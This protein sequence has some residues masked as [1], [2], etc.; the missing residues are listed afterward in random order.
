MAREA[1]QAPHSPSLILNLAFTDQMPTELLQPFCSTDTAR[2]TLLRPFLQHEHLI[3]TDG[4]IF[5][6]IPGTDGQPA[7][8]PDI[9]PVLLSIRAALEKPRA[10]LPTLPEE[11]LTVPCKH[12]DGKGHFKPCPECDGK[13]VTKCCECEQERTCPECKGECVVADAS[14]KEPCDHCEGKGSRLVATAIPI[15]DSQYSDILLKKLVE[16]L[17]IQSFHPN[18]PYVSGFVGHFRANPHVTFIGGLMPIRAS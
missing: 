12:C 16:H 10:P 14:G 13:G 2:P 7:L 4:R 9:Y 8:A 5:I 6:A 3:G 1:Q 17:E 11:G 18:G 15:G